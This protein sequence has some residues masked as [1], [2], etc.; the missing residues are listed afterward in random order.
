MNRNEN[1]KINNNLFSNKNGV[2][3]GEISLKKPLQFIL[4]PT[5]EVIKKN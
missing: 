4:Y 3:G 1:K 5:F 2:R